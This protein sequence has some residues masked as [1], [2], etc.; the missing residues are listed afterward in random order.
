MDRPNKVSILG[1]EWSIEYR[2]AKDDRA[3]E[4]LGG[5]C[6]NTIKMIVV[7]KQRKKPKPEECFDLREYERGCLRHEIV[8]AFMYESGLAHDSFG[9]EHWAMCEEMVDWIAR[10]HKKIHKAFKEAGAL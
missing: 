8:H 2:K 3:L 10:Q 6:D 4:N 7:S 9:S 5:Y 1:T